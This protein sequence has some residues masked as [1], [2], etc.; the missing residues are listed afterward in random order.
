MSFP[1]AHGS[2][3]SYE[4]EELG[5]R[6]RFSTPSLGGGRTIAVRAEPL[7]GAA[8]ITWVVLESF[9]PEHDNLAAFDAALCR[10][11]ATAGHAAI[12]F[13]SQGQGDS[14]LGPGALGV[15]TQVA[16]AVDAVELAR[17][18]TASGTVGLVGVRFGGAIAA[19]A[20]ARAEVSSLV[21]ID[22]IVKGRAFLRALVRLDLTSDVALGEQAAAPPKHDPFAAAR[23]AGVLEMEGLAVPWP[24]VEE[25]EGLDLL[26]ASLPSDLPA[27]VV[28][29]SRTQDPRAELRALT[30]RLGPRASLEVVVDD[31]A[32]RFG[33]PPWRLAGP[34]QKVDA[35]ADLTRTVVERTV[36]WCAGEG[37]AR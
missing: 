21:L 7:G 23:E 11:L 5:F 12:R 37:S 17:G 3:E 30:E 2:L 31:N 29:V 32:F 13:H 16:G 18:E 8:P 27:L 36:R 1:V 20:A 6:E 24:A 35:L 34:R 19:L 9:G 10:S 28:A 33:L 14:E 25:I 15:E 26:R 4:R 22:P